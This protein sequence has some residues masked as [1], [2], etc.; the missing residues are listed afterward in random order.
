[1]LRK[2]RFSEH[3]V[4]SVKEYENTDCHLLPEE[5]AILRQEFTDKVDLTPTTEKD[6]YILKAKQYVGFIVLPTGKRIEIKPK[7]S[8]GV[9]FEMLSKAHDLANF[10]PERVKYGTVDD[11]FEFFIE[12]FVSSVE[13]IVA[14]GILRNFKRET[15]ELLMIRG[16]ILLT[17]TLRSHPGVQDRH[18]CSFPEHTADIDENRI[19][20]LTCLLLQPYQFKNPNINDRVRRL[21]RAFAEVDMVFNIDNAFNKVVYHRLNEHYRPVLLIAEMILAHLSPSGSIGPKKFRAYLVDMN[22]LFEK[23]IETI[24][25]E[26]AIG[27]KFSIRPQ[28]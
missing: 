23:Y 22:K 4:I 16:K 20:K 25:T 1:M 18:H 27:T 2:S 28:D 3:K 12:Y 11:L 10:L 6:I 9:I 21:I 17:E 7:V 24:L 26:A 19:L 13:D 8:T 5:V 15:D 14:R